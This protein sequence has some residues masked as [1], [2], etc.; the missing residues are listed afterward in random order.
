MQV[1]RE[2]KEQSPPWT[3]GWG[4]SSRRR[5]ERKEGLSHSGAPPPQRA[6]PLAQ[7]DQ[8]PGFAGHRVK[9]FTKLLFLTQPTFMGTQT[10]QSTR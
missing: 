7:S 4:G 2:G 9:V 3:G 10:V 8:F 1:C 6:E 5:G